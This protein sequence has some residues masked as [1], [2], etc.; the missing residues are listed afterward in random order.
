MKPQIVF[1]ILLNNELLVKIIFPIIIYTVI[2]KHSHLLCTS[3]SAQ[4]RKLIWGGIS[5]M[6]P[7]SVSF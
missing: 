1:I 4:H 6:I 7:L 3:L 5:S 2:R